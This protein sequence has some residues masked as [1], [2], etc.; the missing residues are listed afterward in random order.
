MADPSPFAQL[1][2]M[3]SG[4][5]ER[6][7]EVS[8]ALS[9]LA[10]TLHG[11]A[12]T[13][14]TTD[15]K[16]NVV[17]TQVSTSSVKITWTTTPPTTMTKWHV[18]RDGTDLSGT[19]AWGT[20][21]SATANSFQFNSLKTNVPYAFGVRGDMATGSASSKVSFTLTSSGGGPVV[22]TPP[23]GD[24]GPTAAAALNW[25]TPD[26]ISDEFNYTGDPDPNKWIPCGEK[27]VGW[28]GHNLNGRRM[29]ENSFVAN[30]MLTLRGDTNGNTGW[31]RQKKVVTHG[32]WE[33]RS[34]SRNTGSSG[35]LY[36]PLHL[37]WPNP[38]VWPGN[39]EYDFVEYMNPDA[40][41]AGAWLHYP[42]PNLP[43]QQIGE[44][45]AGV[46]MTQWHNFAFEWTADHLKGWIDGVEWYTVSGG[47][48]SSR[49]NIQ[50]M[51]A[52]SLTHQLDNFTG[53]GGLRAAVFEIAWVRFYPV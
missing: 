26:P 19:G 50:A 53:D 24:D 21:L 41:A 38:E 14:P 52:G 27:G 16:V 15:V 32:R 7:G 11:M 25:G 34:R 18:D 3:V 17:A 44:D 40:Q 37:I 1:E 30:G 9:T 51:P 47:A 42:H 43:V 4:I 2:Q 46:D 20:D 35:G 45:K 6:L 28:D 8:A 10:T 39:G 12:S 36:H 29:P 22:I 31:L 49:K 5:A 13:P 23:T 33:I 48:N